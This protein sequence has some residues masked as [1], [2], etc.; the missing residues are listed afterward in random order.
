MLHELTR[1][2]TRLVPTTRPRHM[3]TE[4]DELTVALDAAAIR[5][6]GLSRTQLL[7]RLALEGHWAAQQ[8]AQERTDRR[9]A[10]LR[11]LN[12]MFTGQY[13]P[14][15]LEEIREGWPE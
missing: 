4:T 8:V 7:A 9:R 10:A 1:C 2:Y 11:D 15:Y 3:V 6:P 14:N 13:G 12:G 5:W